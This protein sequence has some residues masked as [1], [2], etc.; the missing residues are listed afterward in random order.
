VLS[1]GA[2]PVLCVKVVD[3]SP[4]DV[5]LSD[6]AES[7]GEALFHLCHQQ[8]LL[9]SGL[10]P[11]DARLAVYGGR[12]SGT[13]LFAK[14]LAVIVKFWLYSS[15]HEPNSLSLIKMGDLG[16]GGRGRTLCPTARAHKF[17]DSL[18]F[19]IIGVIYAPCSRRFFIE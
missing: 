17:W 5:V 11:D 18:Q 7:D 12:R 6:L 16:G 4:V 13:S 1:S 19:K 10:L 8:R 15:N 3:G 2:S 9:E 14:P